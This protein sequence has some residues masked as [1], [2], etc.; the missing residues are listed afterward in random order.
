VAL[1]RAML[2]GSHED[3]AKQIKISFYS[4]YL[5]HAVGH[6]NPDIATSKCNQEYNDICY[7]I[8]EQETLPNTLSCNNFAEFRFDSLSIEQQDNLCQALVSTA[9]NF[10][11]VLQTGQLRVADDHNDKVYASK[12][13]SS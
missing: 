9:N 11:N 4:Y 1:T 10:H 12:F 5:S 3:D 8:S 7:I 6:Q 2:E 13:N